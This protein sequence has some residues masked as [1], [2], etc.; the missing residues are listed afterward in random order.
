LFI[1]FIVDQCMLTIL[2]IKFVNI[3]LFCFFSFLRVCFYVLPFIYKFKNLNVVIMFTSL[4]SWVSFSSMTITK[5]KEKKKKR[6]KFA[7]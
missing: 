4:S 3:F 1:Q 6:Y 2:R 5:G 7:I